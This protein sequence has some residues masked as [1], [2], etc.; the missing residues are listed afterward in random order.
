MPTNPWKPSDRRRVPAEPMMPVIDS[1]GWRPQ[2]LKGSD[3]WVYRMTPTE[4]AEIDDAVRAV[5][6][7]GW[8]LMDFDKE[9]FPLPRLGAALK[10]VQAELMEGR[11]FAVLRG[12]PIAGKTRFQ[13]AAAFWGVGNHI[14]RPKSQNGAGHLLGHVR[15]IGADYTKDRGYMSRAEMV[16]HTD[17][18][19]ILSL[20]CL[21]PAKTGGQH[22]IASSVNVY[23]EMLKRR[24]DL[25]KEL[26]FGFYKSRQGEIP[27]GETD[28]F[29]QVPIISIEQGY[30]CA[31]GAGAPIIKAQKLPGVPPLTD[32]QKEAMQMYR[33]LALEFALDIDLEIGD[34]SFVQNYVN[35]HART[36]FTDFPE[37]E[38]KRHLLRLWLNN[39]LRP[40]V[41]AVKKD[42]AGLLVKGAKPS[43][44]LDVEAGSPIAAE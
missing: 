16:F 34:I 23:N 21:H 37:P 31:R 9:R 25:A 14:G 39:G 24:P 29:S 11:G 44:P 22:R 41:A 15:D 32:E 36:E 28:P 4:I 13:I 40:L 33:A 26:S 6:A 3:A 30:F 2:D 20:C 17:R 35:M 5:E 8:Q 27:E 18:A 38:R 1:G 7:N 19:D 43:A 42:N 10:D 12:M